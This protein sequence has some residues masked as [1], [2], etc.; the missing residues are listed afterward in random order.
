M[1]FTNENDGL[2][3][4]ED[5]LSFELVDE[6]LGALGSRKVEAVL[7]K[8]EMSYE[9]PLK[10]TLVAM[11]M[12]NVFVTGDFSGIADS[13]TLERAVHKAFVRVDEQGTTAAAGTAGI[14]APSGPRPFVA[15]HPFFFLIR[16]KLTGSILFIG[17][18]TNPAG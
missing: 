18:V 5:M 1:R 13:A 17:R 14:A 3:L 16:D 9:L 11:G 6:L 8:L 7:P 10:D 12:T 2:A 15:D 4:V